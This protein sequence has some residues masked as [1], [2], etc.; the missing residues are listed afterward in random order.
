M[1][2]RE[3]LVRLALAPQANLSRLCARYGVS[4]KTAYK[5]I[6][7]Y[8]AEGRGGLADRSRR[9]RHSPNQVSDE[10]EQKVLALAQR[11]PAWG[12]RKLHR[13]LSGELAACL[14]SVS[15][16]QAILKRHGRV[17]QGQPQRHEAVGRFEHAE[18]NDLWQMDFKE[19]IVLHRGYADALTVLDDHSR[20]SLCLRAC[21]D[22]RTRTV[23]QALQES[24]RVYGLPRRMTMDN[25][26]P[27]GD[28]GTSPYTRLTVWL[29]KLGIRVSHS[30][31]YHP[32]TQGK[33]ERFH[34][35]LKAELLHQRIFDSP[36]H[37][38]H[39]FDRWRHIYNTIRPHEGIGLLTPI[40]RY[41]PSSRAFP[42]HLPTVEYDAGDHVRKVGDKGLI[43]WNNQR[44]RVGKAFIGESV[45]VR[46]TDSDGQFEIYFASHI[47]KTVNLRKLK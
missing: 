27:W 34:R 6:N 2:L 21:G 37:L 38:Q 4:R 8:Q 16:V 1:D 43:S 14:P 13:L 3:E 29:M 44:I 31:P 32:Q 11:Y 25:G 22:Q 19:S 7:I 39:E 45:A 33:D 24:F 9:P 46:N 35:T 20:F 26:A 36:A 5:W 47:I 28:D 40:D 17:C 30:R 15:T 18:P 12:A 23:Q 42:E 10:V 41:V